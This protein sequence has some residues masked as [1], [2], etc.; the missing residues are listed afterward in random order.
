MKPFFLISLFISTS[1]ACIVGL[2]PMAT[3]GITST[4]G[5]ELPFGGMHTVTLGPETCTCYGNSNFITDYATY[6]EIILYRAPY[7]IFYSYF[8]NYGL[9]QMGSW[10]I[11]ASSDCYMYIYYECVLVMANEGDYGSLPG[12]GT[13]PL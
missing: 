12:T 1:V 9:Y 3:V 13:T 5:N 2:Y 8:N 6:N 4:T 10:R 11:G 7:S